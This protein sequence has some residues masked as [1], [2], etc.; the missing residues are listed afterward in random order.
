MC[1]IFSDALDNLFQRYILLLNFHCSLIGAL[2]I[3][4]TTITSI[5]ISSPF[6]FPS[7]AFFTYHLLPPKHIISSAG[8]KTLLL[9]L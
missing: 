5:L 2:I 9:L 7:S 6:S 4:I 8:V 1:F 3:A